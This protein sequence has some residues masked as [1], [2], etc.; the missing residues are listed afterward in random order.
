MK[1]AE[2]DTHTALYNDMGS[3]Q[4]IKANP[5]ADNALA[6]A[7]EQFEAVFLQTVLKHMR[8]ASEAL[9]SDDEDNPFNSRQQQFYRSMYDSQLAMEMSRQKSLGIADM[10][11]NQLGQHE[12]FKPQSQ[13]VAM[14]QQG[15][16]NLTASL[17]AF[18][19]AGAHPYNPMFSQGAAWEGRGAGATLTEHLNNL[20]DSEEL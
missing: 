5:D 14:T 16:D 6:Q 19:P 8:Q 15:A 4:A 7:A 17:P 12:A 9:Q 11:V 18:S 1:I 10:L 3:L 13:L 2:N 20:G